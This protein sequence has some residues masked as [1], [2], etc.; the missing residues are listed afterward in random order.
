MTETVTA[1]FTADVARVLEIVTHALYA[2]RDVFLRELL[3]NGSDACDKLRYQSQLS[4]G[5]V[6]PDHHYGVFVT[7]EPANKLL[8]VRDTGIG[9]D[10]AEL[11]SQLGTIARSGTKAILEQ[12]KDKSD[13][14]LIGQ[15]G[16]G[17]YASFMVADKVEVISRKAGTGAAWHWESTGAESFTLRPASADEAAILQDRPGT[18]VKL[19][20]KDDAGEYLLEQKLREIVAN[21]ADHIGQPIYIGA[22]TATPANK[23]SALWTSDP[24]SVSAEDY[25]KFYH[26]VSGGWEM[27]DPQATIH[28][29]AEGML[30]YSALLFVP[31][32]RPW[33]LY[34][35]SRK[36]AVRLYVRRMFITDSCPDLMYPWLR[37]MRGVID[38][39]DLPLNIS[40]ETLQTSPLIRKIRAG[41]AT[42]ILKELAQIAKDDLPRFMA[43]WHQF[44]AVMKEGLYDA[45]D[46]R[47]NLFAIAR[48]TSTTHP[49]GTTLDDYM[50]RAKDNQ[51]QIYYL[52]GPNM[53]ALQNSPYLEGFK[54]RGLEVLLLTDTIDDFWIPVVGDYHGKAFTSV[55]KGEADLSAFN[56]ETDNGL[57]ND[58]PI[59]APSFDALIALLKLELRE[60]VADVRLSQ[61]LQESPS[62]LVAQANDMDLHVSRILA[63]QQ[64]YKPAMKR[65]LEINPQHKLVRDL[66]ASVSDD[67]SGRFAQQA[68]TLLY[69]LALILQGE[70]L[71]NPAAFSNLVTDLIAPV[72]RKAG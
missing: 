26:S 13:L 63:S 30:E 28:F 10:D 55:T 27:D 43:I 9:M 69:N 59:D 2:N 14:P 5:L 20:L 53:E 62:C 3:A 17:F 36:H 51:S 57:K 44:G 54:A 40:R 60:N 7:S 66:A 4:Q 45:Q 24:K 16:V 6:T 37:F 23:A 67:L 32:L 15:F 25:T 70:P 1:P 22:D 48:F 41:V 58:A 61:R 64:Q 33:D 49:E 72:T 68:P 39:N 34:D 50:A 42:K 71:S 56:V 65:V 19:H 35:P 31:T 12:L 46:H 52:T 47:E 21:Y 8:I 38:S 29:R 11:T 18:A